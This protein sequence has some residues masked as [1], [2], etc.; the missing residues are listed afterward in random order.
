MCIKNAVVYINKF[1]EQNNS[2]YL[3][4][5]ILQFVIQ[6]TMRALQHIL[7]ISMRDPRKNHWPP[8]IILFK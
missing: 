7:Y 2:V 4:K 1:T 3:H 8:L 5:A 6:A